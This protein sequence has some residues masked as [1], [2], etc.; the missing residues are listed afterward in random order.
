[1]TESSDHE[2]DGAPPPDDDTPTGSMRLVTT[3]V[4]TPDG[5]VG[6]H[7]APPDAGDRGRLEIAGIVVEKVATA[8]AGEIDHVGGS[9]RRV[10][11]V[12]AGREDGDGRPRVSARLT[13]SVAALDIR[14][15]ITYPASVRAVSEAVREHVRDRVQALTAFSVT[16]VDIAVTALPAPGRTDVAP[17]GRVR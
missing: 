10:L 16:R 1:M 5:D 11:G 17:Q 7:A 9:A 14:L 2:G 12:T 3:T 4:N 13:G 15:S 6:R 8:A